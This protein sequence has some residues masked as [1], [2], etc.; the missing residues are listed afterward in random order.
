MEVV[1]VG[2][3]N[4]IGR[5]T[6]KHLLEKKHDVTVLDI[7]SQSLKSLPQQTDRY[8]IDITDYESV[9]KFFRDREMDVLVNCAGVQRQGAVEDAGIQEFEQHIQTN[10]L[11]LVNVVKSALPVLKERKGKIVNISSIAGKVAIPFLSGYS[12]SKFAVEGFSD[13]LRR[14]LEEVDTVLIEPGRVKTG[15]NQKG[16]DNLEKHVNGSRFSETYREK[17]DKERKGMAPEKA[18]KKIA[19]I[20]EN[21]KKPRYTITREAWILRKLNWLTPDRLKDRFFR[22]L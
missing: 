20:V 22:K 3:A 1:V 19:E 16:V 6:V 9:Q 11:G 7:D 18:G 2:G 12:A 15:F 17:L 4:G 13:S 8:N 10:Y 21:G 5:E 14:E